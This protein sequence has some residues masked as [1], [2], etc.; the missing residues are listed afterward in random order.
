L[1]YLTLRQWILP[2]KKAV[3]AKSGKWA[4]K[5]RCKGDN[6]EKGNKRGNVAKK[7]ARSDQ[8]KG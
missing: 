4:K 6:M 8:K 5:I 3:Q 7:A 1:P 2:G